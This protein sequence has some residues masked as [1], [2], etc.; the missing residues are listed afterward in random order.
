MPEFREMIR[1]VP[2]FPK[3]GIL[4]RDITTLLKQ[5]EAFRAVIDRLVE[6]YARERIDQV[7]GI[8]SRG[9]ILGSAMAYR[10]GAGLVPMRKPGKLPHKTLKVTYAL[11][12]GNDSLEM[13]ED[14]LS[15]GTNVLIVDD[16][17]ATGG[18]AG[19]AVSLARKAGARVVDCAFLIELSALKGREKL[20]GLPVFSLISY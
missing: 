11:E 1:D 19:A 18:T 5:P 2:D 16:L 10:L 8:E 6:H 3:P 15:A 4:F 20:Q 14:A 9:F 7:V 17:L 12:Y 13:H